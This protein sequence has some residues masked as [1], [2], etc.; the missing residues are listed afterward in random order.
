LRLFILLL[1]SI[2]LVLIWTNPTTEDFEKWVREEKLT[3]EAISSAQKVYVR[4]RSYLFFSCHEFNAYYQRD[5]HRIEIVQYSGFGI[6]KHFI[7]SSAP[8]IEE[9]KEPV[10][11]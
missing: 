4:S 3:A 11:W 6:L 2:L 5:E 9:K 1:G 7:L 8:G 10:L